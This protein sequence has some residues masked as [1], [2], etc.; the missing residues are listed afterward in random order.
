MKSF[1]ITSKT[2]RLAGKKC[3]GHKMRV[4]FSLQ[5]L[6]ETFFALLNIWLVTYGLGLHSK[7]LHARLHAKYAVLLLDLIKIGKYG[8][9]L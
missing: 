2:E 3:F 7:C 8:Q 9:I 5:N 1:L 6:F 4:L